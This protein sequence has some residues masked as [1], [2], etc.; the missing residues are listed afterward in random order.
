MLNQLSP[1]Y[2]TVLDL[3]S[4]TNMDPLKLFIALGLVACV[5]CQAKFRVGRG[6][7]DITGLLS[8]GNLVSYNKIDLYYN[9]YKQFNQNSGFCDQD[10]NYT[11]I[12]ST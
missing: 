12:R 9:L 8:D 5:S 1:G 11:D 10:R 4:N 2:F 3:Y 7:T 6:I